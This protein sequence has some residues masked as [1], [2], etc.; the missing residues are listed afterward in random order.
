MPRTSDEN[1]YSSRRRRARSSARRHVRRRQAAA[2]RV[3]QQLLG[4]RLARM[5]PARRS[6][7]RRSSTT[8]STFGAVD[9]LT[10][11]VHRR[12]ARPAVARPPRADGVEVLQRQPAGSIMRWQLAHA[13][14]LRCCSIRSRTDRGLRASTSSSNGGTTS[15]GGGGGE[16]S[17]F[18]R[19]HLPRSTGDVRCGVRRHH[20][21]ARPCRAA[22]ARSSC[23]VTRRNWLP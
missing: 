19:I 15:G 14:F 11:R 23:S 17:M 20:Q 22:P 18:S 4:H 12:P 21:H 5:S 13:G 3:C 9:E 1:R 8:P 7:A 6:S 2:E 10:R 16:P